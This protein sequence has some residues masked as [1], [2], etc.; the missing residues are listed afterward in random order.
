[1]LNKIIDFGIF[2]I[3]FISSYVLTKEPFE[4]YLNYI[5]L[6]ILL[7]IF[8]FKYKFPT[9]ILYLFIPLLIFGLINIF[10]QNNTVESFLKIY[11][12]IFIGIVFFYYV[13]VYYERDVKKFFS[14]YMSWCIVVSIIG[15]FQLVSYFIGFKYGYNFAYFGLNKWGIT[16]GGLG[17][18]INSIFCEPSYFASTVGPAFFISVYNLVFNNNWF[19]SKKK[20]ILIV[21]TYI[22]T[23]SSLAYL[24]ILIVI[25]LLLLNYGIVRYIVFVIPM[26]IILFLFIY[27]NVPEFKDRFDGTTALYIDGILENEGAN[28]TKGGFLSQYKAKVN[29]LGKVHGSSFVQYNNFIITKKN[30]IKNPLFGSGLGSHQYAF[31]KYNLNAF[32]GDKYKNNNTDANSM[33]LRIISET[34]L[35][36]L[37]FIIL[38]IRDNYIKRE[39]DDSKNT[40]H[41]LISNA[42]LVIILLQLF[43]QGNYTFGGFMA[44]MWLYYYTKQSYLEFK[45]K[46]ENAELTAENEEIT[47][48]ST[49]Q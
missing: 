21:I 44:Y 46:Q 2:S 23:F 16:K 4:F 6:I 32:I 42:T 41:W 15:L 31:E 45:D 48:Q 1:M 36:G 22:L 9:K 25:I 29:I 33:L 11:L 14:I 27:N 24:S 8:G 43:R 20:S 38:F 19:I 49:I 30:F 5:P 18:R 17:I 40:Y 35:F 37:I 47:N 12:N 34:G 13:F 7:F 39:D 3:L 26:S 10:A 28:Q